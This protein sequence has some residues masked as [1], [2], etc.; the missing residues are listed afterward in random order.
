MLDTH[1][2]PRVVVL[3]CLA[4]ATDFAYGQP[5]QP[6]PPES[7]AM[8]YSRDEAQRHQREWAD[9]RKKLDSRVDLEVASSIGLKLVLIPPGEF[10]MGSSKEQVAAVRR[11]DPEVNWRELWDEQPQ[12]RVTI[13]KPFY[14]GVYEVTQAEYRRVVGRNPSYFA[15][16]GRGK[17]KVSDMD[18]SRFPVET[19]G[20]YESL[21]FCNKLSEIDGFEPYYKL[22]KVQRTDGTIKSAETIKSADVTIAGGAGYRLPTEAE[23]EYACRAGSATAFCFGDVNNGRQCNVRGDF[24]HGT[25]T[26]GPFLQ[27][28]TP[29][30]SY[31]DSENAFGLYD[32]HGN[33]SEWC[34]DWYRATY[35]H[36]SPAK[37]PL[38][39]VVAELEVS[40]GGSWFGY[41]YFSRTSSRFFGWSHLRGWYHGFRV[42]R[43]P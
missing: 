11:A 6:L 2:L 25:K 38:N 21:Q 32:M 20:W 22:S 13:T 29:V 23:W 4:A 3:A 26:E 43:T 16:T 40:R 39:H 10:L 1:L 27:R 12:H 17:N 14:L 7:A 15:A 9:Y 37:D 34:E 19:V 41:P 35:Y 30:G 28:T 18:T 24:P 33:V 42:A 5:G 8:P 36:V 31:Q